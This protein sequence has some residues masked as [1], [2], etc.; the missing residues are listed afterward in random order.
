MNYKRLTKRERDKYGDSSLEQCGK[1]ECPVDCG[2]CEFMQPAFNRLAELEDK[3]ENGTLVEVPCPLGKQ[4][5]FLVLNKKTGQEEL[6]ATEYWVYISIFNDENG[7][8]ILRPEINDVYFDY[9]NYI[10]CE[11][12][13]TREEAEK[14]LLEMEG[15]NKK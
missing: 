1:C 10:Q 2:G 11:Y 13:Q 8:F 4:L 9:E 5:F 12:W 14:R 6:F 15:V 3:I 7:G